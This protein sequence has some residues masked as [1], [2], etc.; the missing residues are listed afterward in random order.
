MIDLRDIVQRSGPTPNETLSKEFK[1]TISP[2][3][4]RNPNILNNLDSKI[5]YHRQ[6]QRAQLKE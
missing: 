6:P 1:P 4:P 3:K 5:T 2:A